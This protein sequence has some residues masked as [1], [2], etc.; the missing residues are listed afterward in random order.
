MLVNPAGLL[1]WLLLLAAAIAGGVFSLPLNAVIQSH[2][3]PDQRS[4]M[5]AANN[6]MNA[7]FMVAS[8]A[9]IA[10]LS[11]AGVAPQAMLAL[12]ALLNLAVAWWFRGLELC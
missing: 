6:V 5:V 1:A 8:A 7:L 3:A 9:I 10:A 2:A 11:V 4:R 12:A